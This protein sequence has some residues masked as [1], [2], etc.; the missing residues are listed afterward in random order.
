MDRQTI[1]GVEDA[2]VTDPPF[3]NV[4]VKDL[5]KEQ[6]LQFFKEREFT[7][8]NTTL[9]YYNSKNLDLALELQKE[10]ILRW[11]NCLGVAL[12]LANN[13]NKED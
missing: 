4:R 11:R 10:G 7:P 1:S 6:I 9:F 2:I 8:L 3:G 13:T 5:T 12:E